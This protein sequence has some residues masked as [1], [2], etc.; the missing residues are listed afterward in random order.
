PAFSIMCRIRLVLPAPRKPVT[1]VAGILVVR[2]VVCAMP[3]LRNAGYEGRLGGAAQVHAWRRREPP[4]SCRTPGW[5][6]RRPTA[7]LLARGSRLRV[8]FPSPAHARNSGL[9][10]RRSPLTVAGAAA[11]SRTLYGARSAFPLNP[12]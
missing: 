11:A 7:G 9:V 8:A 5:N 12:R 10:T 2:V 6:E 4:R 3:A 1:M